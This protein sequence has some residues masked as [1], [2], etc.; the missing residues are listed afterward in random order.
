MPY[1]RLKAGYCTR[2]AF[3]DCLRT[4]QSLIHS[5]I[6]AAIVIT[7]VFACC[8]GTRLLARLQNVYIAFNIMYVIFRSH[9]RLDPS[10][11]GFAF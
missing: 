11:S 4:Y 6:Y 8:L 7:H 5:G 1:M 9:E 3:I 10:E 2:C